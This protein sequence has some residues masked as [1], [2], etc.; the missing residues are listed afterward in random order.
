MS[1]R[2]SG[3]A[4]L[5][6][7]FG[8]RPRP[9]DDADGERSA[10]GG[11]VPGRL[12]AR[13]RRRG[14]WALLLALALAAVGHWAWWYR[15]RPHEMAPAASRLL[16]EDTALPVRLWI[17]YPHQNLGALGRTVER[18]RQVV[19][20]AARL[21]ELPE[22]A[23]PRLG[24]FGIPAA[25]ELV[26]AASRDGREVAAA[27]RLYPTTA[28]L[29]R[30]A[31]A[32]ARNPWLA[33][34]AV[35]AGGGPA[36][37]S[38]EGRTWR[39]RTTGVE[40]RDA[41]VEHGSDAAEAPPIEV[42]D[43][44]AP[45]LALLE[46]AE[47]APPL[48]AGRYPLRREGGDLVVRR[49]AL[50]VDP[51]GGGPPPQVILLWTERRDGRAEALLLME[52][53]REGLLAS[54]PSAAAW[55]RPDGALRALPGG[56][57]L[58]QLTDLRARPFGGGELAA[59]E[60]AVAARAEQLGPAWLPLASGRSEPPLA[61]GGWLAIAPAAEQAERLHRLLDEVPI[62]GAAEAQ[63]WGDVA[64]VLRAARGYRTLS[65]WLAEDG[66]RGELR[67]SR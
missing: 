38:W 57:I 54:L 21:A 30:L 15:A 18:P 45:T 67:L 31:G 50:G 41:G 29:A 25:R 63:R 51:T 44:G 22:P 6:G 13:R 33:G 10:G 48:P 35:R 37:V 24:G 1:E 52:G 64:T 60:R 46:L 47:A 58:R 61:L 43:D 49:G 65:C 27:I 4:P 39:L 12:A 19:A 14:C 2:D 8:D 53:Q 55:A 26:V 11:A 16:R 28:V 56:S 59:T 7:V 62:L 36:R 20:A 17:P 40:P 32:V 9:R 23:I 34:G 3:S 42:A 66:G 5:S